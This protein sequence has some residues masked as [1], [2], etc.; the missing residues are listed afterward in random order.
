MIIEQNDAAVTPSTREP[1]TESEAAEDLHS[2]VWV[3]P[4]VTCR[5]TLTNS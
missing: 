5:R 1:L 3:A 2:F 4:F